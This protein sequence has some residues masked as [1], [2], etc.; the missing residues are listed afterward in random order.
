ML[1]EYQSF[2]VR[3]SKK[4]SVETIKAEKIKNY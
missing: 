1:R 3:S 4:A 2:S